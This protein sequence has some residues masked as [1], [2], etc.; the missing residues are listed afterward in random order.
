LI[1]R[2]LARPAGDAIARQLRRGVAE[3]QP[4][5]AVRVSCFPGGGHIHQ[6]RA[7]REHQLAEQLA[8]GGAAQPLPQTRRSDGYQKN[9]RYLS[10]S[11]GDT[12]QW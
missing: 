12:V 5:G 6:F 7:E 1:E 10:R 9:S 8:K 4:S 2:R 3:H 11:H